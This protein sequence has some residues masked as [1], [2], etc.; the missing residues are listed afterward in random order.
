MAKI[1][2]VEEIPTNILVYFTKVEERYDQN[3]LLT[4]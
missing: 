3:R 4:A 2:V 1:K